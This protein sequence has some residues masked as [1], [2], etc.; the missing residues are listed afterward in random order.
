MSSPH[1]TEATHE[2][3]LAATERTE[4]LGARED[5][6]AER[7]DAS[8][9]RQ[10]ASS[11]RLEASAERVQASEERRASRDD[12]VALTASVLNLTETVAEFNDLVMQSLQKSEAAM[13]TAT[14]AGTASRRVEA[15]VVES[16]I[17]RIKLYW[18]IG[19]TATMT[20]GSVL[21]GLIV[22]REFREDDFNRRQ[23]T[24]E[25]CVLRNEAQIADM[26]YLALID[27]AVARAAAQGDPLAKELAGVL[28]PRPGSAGELPDCEAQRPD[29]M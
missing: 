14:E 8:A 5:A 17:S 15:Q 6:V 1:E 7:H 2:H 10:D 29:P 18:L 19:L 16:R 3:G 23:Q 26:A 4:A 20:L 22:A 27:E 21:A 9:E 24:Y 25:N 13:A 28:V 12:I 11:E